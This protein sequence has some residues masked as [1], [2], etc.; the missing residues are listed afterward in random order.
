[1]LDEVKDFFNS[2]DDGSQTLA[3]SVLDK[4]V[5]MQAGGSIALSAI[6]FLLVRKQLKGTPTW[7]KSIGFVLFAYTTYM[8]IAIIRQAYTREVIK[9][10][11]KAVAA[12]LGAITGTVS[13]TGR[14]TGLDQD[15]ARASTTVR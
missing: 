12:S 3:Q 9:D 8:I 2:D 14:R 15:A 4:R 7:A 5:W 10:E 6:V 1:M 13:A 11:A